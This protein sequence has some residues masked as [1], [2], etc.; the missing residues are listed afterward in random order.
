MHHIISFY[1]RVERSLNALLTTVIELKL[2]AVAAITGLSKI[3]IQGNRIPAATGIPNEL[4]INAPKRFC[5][6]FFSVARDRAMA[7]AT[8]F[9]ECPIRAISAP[10][11]MPIFALAR[12]GASLMPSPTMAT[13]LPSFCNPLT[14]STLS[15]GNTC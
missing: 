7:S 11:A 12:A 4:Y 9:N 5:L 2:I 8:P 13:I 15:C 10:I 1:K 3:P 6:M 14:F